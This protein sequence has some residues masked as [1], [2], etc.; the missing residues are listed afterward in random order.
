MP[1]WVLE[2]KQPLVV[3]KYYLVSMLRWLRWSLCLFQQKAQDSLTLKR[4]NF[5]TE[6]ETP[7]TA[8][9]PHLW[10]L[11]CKKK[12]ENSMIFAWVGA[13]PKL[14]T[15]ILRSP[16]HL[17]MCLSLKCLDMVN[18]NVSKVLLTCTLILSIYIV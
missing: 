1:Y 4:H 8:L 9:L 12:F 17:I 18:N 16:Q 7:H 3:C 6:I 14:A 2:V 13:T 5:K 10:F 15:L 11:S